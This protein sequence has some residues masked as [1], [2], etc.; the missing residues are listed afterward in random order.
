MGGYGG[1]DANGDASSVGDVN[2]DASG[3]GDATGTG[4][5]SGGAESQPPLLVTM[6]NGGPSRLL[7]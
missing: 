6:S 2:G 4:D 1:D 5:A 7:L 3:G